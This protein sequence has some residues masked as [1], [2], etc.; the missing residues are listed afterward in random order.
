MQ[1]IVG[2]IILIVRFG[3]G[4]FGEFCFHENDLSVPVGQKAAGSVAVFLVVEFG[5]VY[6]LYLSVGGY[7]YYLSFCVLSYNVI[8]AWNDA[9]YVI[10][11]PIVF[12]KS[13]NVSLRDQFA[14]TVEMKQRSIRAV[15]AVI[16]AFIVEI[17]V[18]FIREFY[19]AVICHESD[20]YKRAVTVDIR[21]EACFV[22]VQIFLGVF[23]LYLSE[24]FE[25][26]VG[27]KERIAFFVVYIQYE[28]VGI[29]YVFDSVQ[30]MIFEFRYIELVDLVS[31]LYIRFR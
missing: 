23:K 15:F 11:A 27:I 29:A 31:S 10:V 19:T 4:F 16:K 13:F 20:A 17:L 28:T 21:I 8:S 1:G 9:V 14:V 3:I 24:L 7:L 30:I 6:I 2:D 18:V 12:F 22:C 26:S 25:I 5:G